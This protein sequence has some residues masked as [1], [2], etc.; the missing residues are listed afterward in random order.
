MTFEDE[1]LRCEAWIAAALDYAHGTHTIEDV[2][3]ACLAGKATL[4]PGEQAAMV[5]EI[6]DYPRLKILHF[7]LAGGDLEELRDDLRPFAERWGREMGCARVTI[8]GRR[9]WVKALPGYEEVAT[10]CGKEL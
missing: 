6:E 1:W 7:W 2:K 10:I 8:T 5:V 3:A 4:I 9:G